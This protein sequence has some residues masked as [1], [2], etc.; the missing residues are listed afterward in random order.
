VDFA[1][2]R[3]LAPDILRHRLVLNFRARA[4]KVDA[5]ALIAR[6][7]DQVKTDPA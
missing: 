7:I 1:D 4:D 6:I 3:E 2:V 5:D